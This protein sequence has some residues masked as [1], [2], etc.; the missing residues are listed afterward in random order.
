LTSLIKI[1]RIVALIKKVG[2]VA[3][4]IYMVVNG[5]KSASLAIFDLI[6][7]PLALLDIARLSAQ[8]I[9][10]EPCLERS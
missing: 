9:S 3:L 2:N 7:A 1:G 6:L 8:P 5:E 4:D 10:D